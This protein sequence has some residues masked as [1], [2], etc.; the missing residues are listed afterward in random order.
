MKNQKVIAP[1]ITK[2]EIAD[3]Y[4]V[5]IKILNGW[6]A[7]AG[8]IELNGK[9]HRKLNPKQLY[10]MVQHLYLPVGVTLAI[11][12]PGF[13]VRELNVREEGRQLY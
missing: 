6:L 3:L 2:K 1:G 12:E 7:D 13:E 9:K 10:K 4:G 5:N 8:I 11:K